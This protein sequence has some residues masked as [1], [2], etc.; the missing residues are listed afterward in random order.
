MFGCRA[1][2]AGFIKMS[3]TIIDKNGIVLIS[4]VPTQLDSEDV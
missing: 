4:I 1:L 3:E 2:N